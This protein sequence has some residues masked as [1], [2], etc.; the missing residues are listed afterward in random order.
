MIEFTKMHGL[1]N[2]FICINQLKNKNYINPNRLEETVRYL[3]NRNFGIGADGIILVKESNVADIKMEIVNKDGSIA[4][5]CGN[6]IRCISKYVFDRKIVNKKDMDIETRDGIKRVSIAEKDSKAEK[7]LVNMGK[8]KF[9]P[10]E[11]P[12]KTEDKNIPVITKRRVL[13]KEFEMN[14]IFMGNPHTIIIVENLDNIDIKK[15]GRLIEEDEIFPEKTNVDFVQILDKS[16]VKMSVWERGVGE[17]FGCGTGACA[18]AV[19]L[20]IR[21]LVFNVCNVILKGGDLKIKVKDNV[22]MEGIA[23]EVFNGK[24]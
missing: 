7:V 16:N 19:V 1:G 20:N 24:I 4:S 13:D 21:G 8:P 15:Y 17:T 18:T 22:Y 23:T 14:T 12:I 11:I 10:D 6:G 2:D 5:M 9:K 3:C